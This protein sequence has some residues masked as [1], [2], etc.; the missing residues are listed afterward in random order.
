MEPEG[1]VARIER[2]GVVWTR[3]GGGSRR[4]A[5]AS[6]YPVGG[7]V[8]VGGISFRGDFPASEPREGGGEWLREV[9]T[10]PDGRVTERV[11]WSGD[12]PPSYALAVGGQAGPMHTEREPAPRLPPA[13]PAQML[14]TWTQYM[15]VSG[16]TPGTIDARVREVG[17]AV[18]AMGHPGA[19]EAQGILDYLGADVARQKASYWNQRR[20]Y[21]RQFCEWA[22]RFGHMPKPNPVDAVPARRV[23]KSDQ[24]SRSLTL[25]EARR[26]VQSVRAAGGSAAGCRNRWLWYMT[27]MLTGLRNG[28]LARMGWQHF[29]LVHG[30][31]VVPAEVDKCRVE[32]RLPVAP[33]L[34]QQLA[35][36]W[37]WAGCPAEGPL[38]VRK[39]R[40]ATEAYTLRDGVF[41]ADCERAGIDVGG[42]RPFTRH[43]LRKVHTGLLV[44]IDCPPD[45]RKALSRH[46]ARDVSDATYVDRDRMNLR[47]WVDR[48]PRLLDPVAPHPERVPAQVEVMGG[49]PPK[50]ETT[51]A[52]T[53]NPVAPNVRCA[54][55]DTSAGRIGGNLTEQH[56][57]GPPGVSPRE[58][59][60]PSRSLAGQPQ[61]AIR[62]APIC[63]IKPR[64]DTSEGDDQAELHRLIRWL[65]DDNDRLRQQI[66]HLTDRLLGHARGA[67]G[68]HPW[69][70]PRDRI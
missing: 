52:Q 3:G 24:G 65:M 29:D 36:A 2:G 57:P 56:E 34:R 18:E 62:R 63:Q 10:T 11:R 64:S 58:N 66:A 69:D 21:L 31:M 47:E 12:G 27:V 33:E 5:C 68:A 32:R 4:T 20:S 59:A 46:A 45:K 19:W 50:C 26:L 6:E 41:K 43:G 9:W 40:G 39:Y 53:P 67:H 54:T 55:L 70:P 38:F 37:Q 15:T 60:P 28:E 7:A 35:E 61:P 49:E 30:D 48:L 13:D 14:A 25:D 1:V 16:I 22:V 51:G 42:P 23:V 44:L 8:A 17:R